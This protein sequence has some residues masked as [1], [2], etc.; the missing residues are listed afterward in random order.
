MISKAD[1]S[2]KLLQLIISE[3]PLDKLTSGTNDESKEYIDVLTDAMTAVT[4]RMV[5]AYIGTSMAQNPLMDEEEVV[6]IS[7]MVH[8]RLSKHLDFEAGDLMNKLQEQQRPRYD[9]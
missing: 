1:L 4:A 5:V 3:M 6:D 9:A 8:L 2:D 7:D